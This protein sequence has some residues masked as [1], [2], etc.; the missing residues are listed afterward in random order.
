MFLQFGQ[1]RFHDSEERL[2]DL[3]DI[4]VKLSLVLL[5]LGEILCQVLLPLIETRIALHTVLLCV[6]ISLGNRDDAVVL[7]LIASMRSLD[8][9]V[10]AESKVALDAVELEVSFRVV[11][12]LAV[13][14]LP[15]LHIHSFVSR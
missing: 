12:A 6:F 14:S 5:E 10:H 7:S 15:F 13:I 8:L 2:L 3:S 9:A 11:L 4:R 1:S